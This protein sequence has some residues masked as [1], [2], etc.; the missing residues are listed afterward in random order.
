M[1]SLKHTFVLFFAWFS[2]RVSAVTFHQS[3]PQIV[4]ENSEV[5][6][7]CSHDD[8][9]LQYMLWYQQKKD[10]VAMTLIGSG[11]KGSPTYEAA[12]TG[13]M[14]PAGIGFLLILLPCQSTSVIFE[15]THPRIVN[16]ATRVEIKCSHDDNTLNVMLWYQQTE[17]GR[18]SAVTF[19][20]SPPQ[21]VKENSE[22]QIECSHDDTSLIIM[23]WYQ[24]KKESVALTLIGSGY[25]GSPTATCNL[26][27]FGKQ[28]TDSAEE[29]NHEIQPPKVKILRPSEKE[30]RNQKDGKRKKTLVCVASEF[31]PNHVTVSWKINGENPPNGVATDA[32]AVRK[33]KFYKITSRLRVTAEE[34]YK[35]SNN[36]TCIVTFYDGTKNVEKSA[37]ISGVEAVDVDT[38]TREKYLKIT[39]SAKLSYGVFIAKS[40]IYG[41]FVTF[42]V[43]KL[44]VSVCFFCF[45]FAF[46]FLHLKL[47]CTFCLYGVKQ[48][49][50]CSVI[51]ESSPAYQ[52]KYFRASCAVISSQSGTIVEKFIQTV[53]LMFNKDLHIILLTSDTLPTY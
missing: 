3:P 33:D 7:E 40:C 17:G 47:L 18:V 49:H 50:F 52:I 37:S 30:C 20:Q 8:A 10:S 13:R 45:I 34:W 19:H 6:I 1:S 25:K 11:Y 26:G 14:Y 24:Q 21:I 27:R 4:K 48:T 39:Q 32:A 31:Y 36:F 12:Q 23:L 35:P 38:M 22:V 44:Q 51:V 5:Q 16:A 29:E 28:K 46:V 9:N 53:S 43:W 42:L 15:P 41:A 2:C